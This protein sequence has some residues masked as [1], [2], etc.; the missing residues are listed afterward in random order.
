[1]HGHDVTASRIPVDA[2]PALADA[3]V[4][5]LLSVRMELCAAREALTVHAIIEATAVPIPI[6]E[7]AAAL[8]DVAGF[9]RAEHPVGVSGA[10]GNDVDHAV[11]RVRTPDGASGAAGNLD[12][13]D[14][15][16][17]RVLLFPI[18]AAE[19]RR[20]DA[21]SVDQDEHGLRQPAP[22][23]THADR[24]RVGVDASNFDTGNETQGI[25]EIRHARATDIVTR[26]H[27]DGGRCASDFFGFFRSAGH[28]DP[29]ELL[30]AQPRERRLVCRAGGRSRSEQRYEDTELTERQWTSLS[31][32]VGCAARPEYPI[33][34]DRS[35]RVTSLVL[36]AATRPTTHD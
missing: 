29:P 18:D 35:G 16:E 23:S 4:V 36:H 3:P 1:L 26:E 10:P 15:R 33:S 24:P 31:N 6:P 13:F 12:T 34:S 8:F 27:E 28:L 7:T 22:E 25:C 2:K 30:E 9:S 14:V 32:K 21:A 17:Q 5:E 11:D 19:Q 20:V